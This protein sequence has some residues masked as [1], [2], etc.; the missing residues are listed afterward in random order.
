[1]GSPVSLSAHLAPNA[2]HSFSAWHKR[3]IDAFEEVAV[4][5]TDSAPLDEVLRLIGRTM[6]ELLDLSRCSVYLRREDGTFQG[7]I[8]YCAGGEPIDEGVSRLISGTESDHF[9]A[10]ILRSVSPVVIQDATEDPRPLRSVMRI[11]G[12]QDMLGIP[13]V[14]DEEV[15]GIIYVDNQGAGHHYTDHDVATAQAFASLAALILRKSWLHRQ[16]ASQA[17]DIERQ[18]K[19]L[20]FTGSVQSEISRSVVD[21][22]DADDVIRTLAN[23]LGK[24]V[25]RYDDNMKVSAWAVPRNWGDRR[26]PTAASTQRRS[27]RLREVIA[28]LDGGLAVATAPASPDFAH[29]GMFVRLTARGEMLGY[30]EMCELG[31]RFGP[32]DSS[33]LIHAADAV[34]LSLTVSRLKAERQSDRL[35]DVMSRIVQPHTDPHALRRSFESAHLDLTAEW[36]GLALF[37]FA[38]HDARQ[39]QISVSERRQAV[40]SIVAS[41]IAAQAGIKVLAGTSLDG[42]DVVLYGAASGAG[43]DAMAIA[44]RA[45]MPNLRTMTGVESAIVSDPYPDPID[46]PGAVEDLFSVAQVV[47]SSH[48]SPDVHRLNELAIVQLLHQRDGLAGATRYAHRMI[49]PLRAYDTAHRGSLVETLEAYV[50]AD[51]NMK[52]A[53]QILNVHENTIRYRL[54]RIRDISTIDPER[55]N[56]LIRVR[57]AFQLLGI[58]SGGF[59][60]HDSALVSASAD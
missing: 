21:G 27:A 44:V 17:D 57:T 51:M 18:R 38:G 30:L 32:V 46:L 34:A 39:R 15:I 9:T 16:L 54:G 7:Q 29:R 59:S 50:D 8:G 2:D 33:A 4:F 41:R 22:A 6:C 14:V 56:D 23:R 3:V 28:K 42:S 47:N 49:R 24:P 35:A 11:W 13:L 45:A 37:Q 1:M 12:V 40:L 20:Q 48:A 26:L 43:V 36:Y 52:L 5:S 60:T 55:F 25:I 53:A 19:L 10:E 58:E 31:R